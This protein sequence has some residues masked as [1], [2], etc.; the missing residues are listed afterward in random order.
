MD[1]RIKHEYM[2]RSVTVGG[3]TYK[4]SVC[5][6]VYRFGGSKMTFLSDLF[7]F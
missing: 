2:C 3:D 5:W 1:G 6:M 4:Q 7:P